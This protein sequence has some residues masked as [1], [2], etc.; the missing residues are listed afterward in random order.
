M[1]KI[2]IWVILCL[3]F[4]CKAQCQNESSLSHSRHGYYRVISVKKE[5]GKT[6]DFS[7]DTVKLISA[8]KIL[9]SVFAECLNDSSS[10]DYVSAEKKVIRILTTRKHGGSKGKRIKKNKAYYFD[11]VSIFWKDY[12]MSTDFQSDMGVGCVFCDGCFVF[13]LEGE[14]VG[15]IYE[16]DQLNGLY[17]DVSGFTQKEKAQ[18]GS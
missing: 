5:K 15:D 2:F 3:S 7:I 18:K 12:D 9:Y 4:S 14:D 11:L 16:T 17:Y 10:N 8:N 6:L 1:L 13:K